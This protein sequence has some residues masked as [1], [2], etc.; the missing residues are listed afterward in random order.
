MEQV[1]LVIQGDR[2]K[3]YD[4]SK[5][6]ELYQTFDEDNNGLMSKAEMS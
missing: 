3:N 1:C 2:A 5:F 4:S 6:D